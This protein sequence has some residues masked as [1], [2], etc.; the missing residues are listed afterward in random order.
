MIISVDAEK[1]W[2]NSA[3]IYDK[4]SLESGQRRNL[5]WHDRGHIWQTHSKHHSQWWKDE[6]ISSKIRK[7]QRYPLS[8]LLFNIVLEV[9][10][11]AVR[12]EKEI[13]GTHVVNEVK[14]SLS[15]D[16]MILN[17][18]NPEDATRKLLELINKFDKIAEYK[19]NTQGLPWWSSG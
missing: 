2:Q 9:L 8:A 19:I 11:T 3:P 12:K 14:L 13:K 10:A 4:N 7:R 6:S 1:L 15:V 18:E 5:P 17:I 16:D